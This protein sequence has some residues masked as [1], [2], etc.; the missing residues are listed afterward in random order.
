[1]TRRSLNTVALGAP[2]IVPVFES[3]VNPAGRWPIG[4]VRGSLVTETFDRIEIRCLSR[5]PDPED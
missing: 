5:R 4:P 1:M 3:S 2:E